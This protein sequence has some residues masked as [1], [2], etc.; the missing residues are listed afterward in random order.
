M[1]LSC[2][3]PTPIHDRSTRSTRD[4][5]GLSRLPPHATGSATIASGM[6]PRWPPG[7]AEAGRFRP[8]RPFSSQ[9][10]GT[11]GTVGLARYCPLMDE[12]QLPNPAPETDEERRVRLAREAA[13]I[14]E[15]EADVEAGRLIP[16]KAVSTWLESL[17]TDHELPRPEPP[18]S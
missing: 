2:R 1:K 9:A 15:A 11:I 18:K 8:E 5:P 10:R 17:G 7:A 6:L 16:G 12:P 14:A 3:R 4:N 13:L